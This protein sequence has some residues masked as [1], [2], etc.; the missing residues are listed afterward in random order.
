L[1]HR[2]YGLDYSEQ[3]SG[4]VAAAIAHVRSHSDELQID[5]DRLGIWTWSGGGSLLSAVL[6][7][8]N[9]RVRCV[10]AYYPVLDLRKFPREQY[11]GSVSDSTAA[12]LSAT[13]MLSH[14][15]GYVPPILIA[16][17]GQDYPWVNASVDDFV[18]AAIPAGATLDLMTH[19]N[20]HHGFD[21]LD[22]DR[23]SREI[24]RRTLAY[25]LDHLSER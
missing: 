4:D 25:V 6:C 15:S 18:R 13:R 1:K 17:V 14:G 11:G 21:I 24:I 12:R 16:R 9:A 2:F 19:P 10:V 23:R 22:N 7:D 3:A 20:G 5:P 8:G